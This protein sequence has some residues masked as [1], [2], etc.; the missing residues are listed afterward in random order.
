MIKQVEREEERRKLLALCEKTPFGC[1]IA[2]IVRSY[3]FEKGFACFWLDDR[4]DAVFCLSDGLMI[5]SGT[6]VDGE[7]TRQFLRAVGAG[8]IMCAVRNAEEL[9][10]SGDSGDVLKKQLESGVP[11]QFDPFGA[12]IRELIGVLEEVGMVEDFEP[13]YLD[14]SHKL[15]HGASLVSEVRSPDTRL[16]GCAI[17]SSISEKAAILSAVA[18][19]PQYRRKGLGARL[20][21][22]MEQFF[23][24]KSLYVFREK[25][26]F[27]EFYKSLGFSKSDTWVHARLS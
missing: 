11:R 25:D 16:A 8:E 3:G 7:E 4:S 5:L 23:P 21:H 12:N 15:R 19:L 17:A 13:F 14:L 9:K 1:K 22:E 18:V 6:I 2:S 20:V 10:L 24:G 26:A 27:K